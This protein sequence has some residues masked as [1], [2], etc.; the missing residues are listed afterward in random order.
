MDAAAL[1]GLILGTAA[2]VVAL[3][4]IW[5]MGVKPAYQGFM[6]NRE[7]VKNV[8]QIPG[9]SQK[10]NSIEGTLSRLEPLITA[11][12]HELHPNSGTSMNDKVTRTEEAVEEIRHAVM[13]HLT[14]PNAHH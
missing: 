1:V 2:V 12:H 5:N 10:V 7:R 3:H 4:G 9:M 8:D 13:D 14:D 11:V 6:K